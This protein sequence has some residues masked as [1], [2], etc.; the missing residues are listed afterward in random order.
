MN[1]DASSVNR[2]TAVVSSKGLPKVERLG[3]QTSLMIQSQLTQNRP[4][5]YNARLH[6]CILNFMAFYDLHINLE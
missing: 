5:I 3:F 2:I 6:I 1:K 4:S